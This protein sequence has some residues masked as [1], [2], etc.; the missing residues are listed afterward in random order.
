MNEENN[1][2]L[3]SFGKLANKTNVYVVLGYVEQ[4]C[5]L[6]GTYI[7]VADFAYLYDTLEE[8]RKKRNKIIEEINLL[9]KK[10]KEAEYSEENKNLLIKIV[11]L[12]GLQLF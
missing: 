4:N 1:I 6:N 11:A 7:K 9:N 3:E 12:Q 10:R 5:G 2:K 8:A